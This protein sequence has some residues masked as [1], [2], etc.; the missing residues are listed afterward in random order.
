MILTEDKKIVID[1]RY[2]EGKEDLLREFAGDLIR[3]NLDNIVTGST[4]A[5][6][7]AKQ[8]TETIPIVLALGAWFCWP[9][10]GCLGSSH[11]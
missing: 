2:G 6:R 10:C 1:Y 5:A 9:L 11:G 8:L 3:L 7:A 4:V